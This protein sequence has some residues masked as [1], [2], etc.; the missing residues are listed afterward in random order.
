VTLGLTTI[1][2]THDQAEALSTAD[3]VAVMKDG[4]IVQVGTPED[5]YD[6]PAS[7]FVADVVG[8]SNFLDLSIEA[9]KLV[10]GGYGAAVTDSVSRLPA[11]PDGR[12][13][14]VLL[15]RPHRLAVGGGHAT[16]LACDVR[17]EGRDVQRGDRHS[18][19]RRR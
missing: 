18:S 4:R 12:H 8:R 11:L 13:T 5:I 9:G 10:V 1:F 17:L 3:R 7:R 15:V 19:H 6:R 16:A 14:H 2:V